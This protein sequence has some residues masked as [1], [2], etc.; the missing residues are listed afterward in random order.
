MNDNSKPVNV[1]ATL[2]PVCGLTAAELRDTGLMGCSACYDAFREMVTQA[3][4]EL[5]HSAV[6]PTPPPLSDRTPAHP[7]PTR[8]AG[9]Q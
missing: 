7:W 9:S 8:R 2:C 1:P 6:E 4:R 3:V 5:H